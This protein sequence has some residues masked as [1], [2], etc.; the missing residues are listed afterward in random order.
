MGS[1]GK[2][3]QA[4]VTTGKDMVLYGCLKLL[5]SPGNLVEG[6]G[7]PH[8]VQKSLMWTKLDTAM[9]RLEGQEAE[10]KAKELMVSPADKPSC[11]SRSAHP[12]T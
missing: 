4:H 9:T 5:G 3:G 12:E 2:T 1:D 10:G 7:D 6:T 11:E 8:Y